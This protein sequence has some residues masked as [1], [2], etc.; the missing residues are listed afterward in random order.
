MRRSRDTRAIGAIARS[1]AGGETLEYGL[2][3]RGVVERLAC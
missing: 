3:Q 2:D 1:L